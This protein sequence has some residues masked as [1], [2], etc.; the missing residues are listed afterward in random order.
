MTPAVNVP[1]NGFVAPPAG[2]VPPPPAKMEP[3]FVVPPA[4]GAATSQDAHAPVASA[5]APAVGNDLT[6]A[7]AALTA[8]MKAQAP[9][10]EPAP[11]TSP[12]PTSGLAEFDV[13]GIEDPIL[14]SMATVLQVSGKG[15]D[16]DRVLGNALDRGDPSLVDV[17]YLR[18]K[19]G[20]QADQLITIAQGIVQA[21]EAQ[22]AQVEKGIHDAAGG[23]A[24]WDAAVAVFN[25]EAP[26]ELRVVI[27]QL[28]NSTVRSQIDAGAK[29]VLEFSKG[30]GALPRTAPS[31]NGV[32]AGASSAQ[33][34]SKE[35]F[36][37]ELRKLNPAS[38]GY[39]QARN[40]LF[41]RRQMGR[42][43]GK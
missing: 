2:G 32:A 39:E 29:L 43:L 26:Q 12:I 14:R 41:A 40:D 35:E 42:Q 4:P 33:A 24:N 19:A 34:L 22:A 36:Q 37:L 38:R 5:A 31:V 3:G 1:T 11:E 23:R 17:A 9:A 25:K 28:L 27:A 10:A 21:V 18:E 13:A 6:A 30:T 7:L 20:N 16:L 8:A 15:L